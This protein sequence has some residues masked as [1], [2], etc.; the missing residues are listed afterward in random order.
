M[1]GP[2]P[3]DVGAAYDHVVAAIGA[4]QSARYG[5]DLICYITPAEHLALP[6]ETGRGGRGE[7]GSAGRPYRR[8]VQASGTLSGHGILTMSKARR[9][10]DWE[11]QF[12]QALFPED[13]R[14]IRHDRS[15]ANE[16]VC[17]MCGDFCANRASTELFEATLR[18]SLKA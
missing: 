18:T 10:C 1:L 5:A 9:D 4:A 12:S 13:A 6:N 14:R 7:G 16:K 15:P 8:S 17:T 2:L 3:T 11:T